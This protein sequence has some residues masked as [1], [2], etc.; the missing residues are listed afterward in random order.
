MSQWREEDG[1]LHR[2]LEFAD[3]AQACADAGIVFVGPPPAAIRA[4]GGKS[5]AKALM[6]ASGVPVVPGYHRS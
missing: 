4:M 2:E 5:E 1:A 3:F 6:V